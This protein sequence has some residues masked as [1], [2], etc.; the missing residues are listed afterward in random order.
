MVYTAHPAAAGAG[1]DQT[2]MLSPAQLEIAITTSLTAF[3]TIPLCSSSIS[4]WA[5]VQNAALASG[6]QLTTALVVYTDF[7]GTGW[8]LL[9]DESELVEG[10]SRAQV[11]VRHATDHAAVLVIG[12]SADFLAVRPRTHCSVLQ[13]MHT[14]Q[15][16]QSI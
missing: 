7:A 12:N 8:T 1:A 14:L 6:P 5:L 16:S 15:R 9:P 10:S 3:D 11:V 13:G 4:R 2:S